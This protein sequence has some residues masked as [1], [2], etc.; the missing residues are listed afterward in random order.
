[1]QDEKII[2]CERA[3]AGDFIVPHYGIFVEFGS[4][5]EAHARYNDGMML[6]LAVDTK[7]RHP[8]YM[9]NMCRNMRQLVVACSDGRCGTI[10]YTEGFR[11]ARVSER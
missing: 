1:M 4:D 11:V 7:F 8:Q 3:R 9:H 6:V 2:E 10:T 5:G